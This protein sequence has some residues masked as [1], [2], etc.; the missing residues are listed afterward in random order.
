MTTFFPVHVAGQIIAFDILTASLFLAALLRALDALALPPSQGNRWKWCCS[1]VVL[2]WFVGALV[3]A[4][5]DPSAPFIVLVAAVYGPLLIGIVLFRSSTYRDVVETIP[6]SWLA[7]IHTV[8]IVFGY[9]FI[10]IYELGGLPPEFAIS[11]A[12]GDIVSGFVGGIAAY[13]AFTG[14]RSA[15]AALIAWNVIGIADFLSVVP[16]A[17]MHVGP[18]APATSYFPLYLIPGFAV[19]ILFLL[20]VYSVRRLW[21]DRLR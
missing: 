20:H 10:A 1:G 15:R 19:P 17:R 13:L 3:A 18:E 4:P 7:G 12:Y 11:A 16:L 2:A 5:R 8:R 14:H 21:L 9:A 6:Q